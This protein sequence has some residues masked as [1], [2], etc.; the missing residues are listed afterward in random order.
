MSDQVLPSLILDD[1]C[2][3][4][5]DFSLSLMVS[6]SAKEK[7]LKHTSIG[8]WFSFLKRDCNSFVR[9]ERVV[10]IYLEGLPL[11]VHYER[12]SVLVRAKEMETSDLF[13]C[14][15]SYVSETSDNEDVKDD[16]SQSG[17]KITTDN[18]V[19]WVSESSCMYNNDLLYDNNHNN[20]MHDKD[21]V[22]FEDPFNLYDILIKR[23]DSGDDLKYPHGFTPSVIN[24][25]EVNKK[26]KGATSNEEIKMKSMELV[27]IKMLWGNSSF[28]YA[29][30]SSLAN[31]IDLPLNGYA[32]IWAYKTANKMRIK[33]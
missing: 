5:R 33:H 9:D 4:D 19:E 29:L 10:W 23:K 1:S 17:D 7:L 25:E 24:M 3:L 31:L 12:F 32:Y 2:I 14:N 26:V 15:D 18:D 27:T 6:I 16:G 21:K 11:K 28:Y 20:I 30:S 22:I 8:S 13:I